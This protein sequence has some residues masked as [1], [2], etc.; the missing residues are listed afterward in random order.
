LSDH[1]QLNGEAMQTEFLDIKAAKHNP[2]QFFKTPRDVLSYPSLSR[3]AKIEILR[4]WETDARLMA[5]AEEENLTGGEA[6]Q[7]GAVVNALISLGDSE[8]MPDG[9]PHPASVSKSGA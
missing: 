9:D 5:V 4:Q 6:N 8:K 3:A 2:T 7:L 1:N